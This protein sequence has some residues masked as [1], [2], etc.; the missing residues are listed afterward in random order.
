MPAALPVAPFAPPP[1]EQAAAALRAIGERHPEITRL[2]IFG[3]VAAGRA[4]VGSDL[5]VFVVYAPNLP[6]GGFAHVGR[7]LDLAEEMEAAVGVKVDLHERKNAE[8]C[9]NPIRSASA[10]GG[11]RLVY[12]T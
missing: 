6:G 5:D 2:E 10:L 1:F 9:E 4:D 7:L 3:S 11:A 8:R 12:G